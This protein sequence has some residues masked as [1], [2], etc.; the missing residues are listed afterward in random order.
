[1]PSAED[2]KFMNEI[3]PKKEA[4]DLYLELDIIANELHKNDVNIDKVLK[5]INKSKTAA[6]VIIH[7]L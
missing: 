6:K 1:M 7:N 5:K 3:D 4:E 2:I